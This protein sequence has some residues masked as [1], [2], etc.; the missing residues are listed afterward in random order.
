MSGRRGFALARH[1]SATPRSDEDVEMANN[2][3]DEVESD[4]EGE[5]V[6]DGREDLHETIDRLSTL[7][8]N[9]SEDGEE[10]A[11]GFQRIPNRRTVPDYFE[12]ISDPVAFSTVRGKIQKKQYASF[13]E[14]VKDVSQIFHN[15]QV[16]NRPSAP[17][18]GAAIKLQ[19]IFRQELDKL[20]QSSQISK[21]EASLPDLGELPPVEESPARDSE[22][23]IS[24]DD[25]DDDDEEEEEEEAEEDDDDDDEYGTG[26]G[27]RRVKRRL[28]QPPSKN[29]VNGDMDDDL[30]KGRGRPP[31]VLTPVEARIS[32]ILKGLRRFKAS[33]GALLVTPFERLPDRAALPDYFQTITNPIAL[34]NIKKKAKRKKYSS[35]DKFLEDMNLMFENAKSYNEDQ[36][37]LYKAAAELQRE[38]LALA[39]QENAKSDDEFRDEDGKLPVAYVEA[40]GNIWRVGDWVHIRN[41]NDLAKPTVGQIFRMWQ[42]R[43]GEKWINACWYYRPEQTVHRFEKHFF[44]REV[45]KTGQYRDHQIGEVVDRCFVMF[46]TRF[47]KGRPRG[48]PGDMHVYVC[49]SRYN[50]E[51]FRFNKIKTWASCVPDEVRDRDYEMDLFDTP[52]PMRKVPSPIKHLLREDAKTSDELPR[53]TWGSP[54]AP[55]IVGAVHRRPPELHETPP[56]ESVP[57]NPTAPSE[58][59]SDPTCHASMISQGRDTHGDQVSGIASYG[60]V[61]GPASPSHYHVQT[62][63]TQPSTPQAG[64]HPP[65]QT[66]VPLPQIPAPATSARPIQYTAPHQP[67]FAPG[68][69]GG[70]SQSPAAMRHPQVGNTSTPGYNASHGLRNMATQSQAGHINNAYN[71]PRPPEVYT[72]PDST[73]EALPTQIRTQLQHDNA[74]RVLFFTAPPSDRSPHQLPPENSGLGHSLRYF[75]GR[76]EWQMQRDTKRKAR[77]QISSQGAS[78]RAGSSLDI[79]DG[80]VAAD[81]RGALNHWFSQIGQDTEKW[82]QETGL[83]H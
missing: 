49:E 10:L 57:L 14:F 73:N 23:V 47:N 1:Q 63:N 15:A 44:E 54:N 69:V 4:A 43:E 22:A 3:T 25:D 7:L 46:V 34:D 52:R 74:G 64:A 77:D 59:K 82:K 68:Y 65:H 17:I 75:A 35:V 11:A 20:V 40:H 67:G 33:S 38:T 78:K 61:L 45:V 53:P 28:Q 18:F 72:L 37:E 50:E 48:L 71:P 39:E 12:I 51:N 76:E 6:I 80:L 62:V 58:G 2:S 60:G 56:P 55:P 19:G 30:H 21:E 5:M 13:Q 9:M 26:V 81:A 8:C 32:S 42:D 36:S 16:Y 24:D 83:S 66:P 27:G 29:R 79:T 31:M 70:F 41:P